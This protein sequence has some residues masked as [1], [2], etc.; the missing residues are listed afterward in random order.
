MNYRHVYHAGNFADLLKHAV[1]KEL[2]RAVTGSR[3]P[4]TVIDTHAGAGLYDLDGDEARRT[5][6]SAAGIGR[7]MAA[8][9]A[10]AVFNDLK[11]VVAST[12]RPGELRLYPGSPLVIKSGLRPRD[13]YV[14]CETRVDDFTALRALMT[15]E[16]GAVIL[17]GD[18]WVIGA[19]RAPKP[20]ASLL[21]LMD[22]PFERG[23]DAEQ[24]VRLSRM[25]LK[26]NPSA[27][28]ATWVPIKDLT[29]FDALVTA[30]ADA[31]GPAPTMV[32]EVRLR[33]LSDP[34]KMNGCAMIVANPPAG[35]DE[36][37][38]QAAD[39]IA[40]TLGETGAFGRVERLTA[41]L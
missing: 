1:L 19:E 29:G 9:D 6:E 39:W 5:G 25:V 24:A 15:G 22:P 30:L 27:V 17:K 10:P 37:S 33:P 31:V 20:P 13:L 32:V 21:L 7:L 26:R 38:R 28:I 16:A 8:R 14:G 23:D 40:Q 2:L 35:L 41:M 34:M 36:R 4:V 11:A 12:N 3:P 18:G